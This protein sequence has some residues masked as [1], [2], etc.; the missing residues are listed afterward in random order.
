[1]AARAAKPLRPQPTDQFT[2]DQI[3]KVINHLSELP[4]L[5]FEDGTTIA[6]N[7]FDENVSA[8]VPVGTISYDHESG[9][10]SFLP[11]MA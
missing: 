8:D 6:L 5:S 2:L 1:M 11:V 4:Y 10:W 3:R 7:E 9:Y